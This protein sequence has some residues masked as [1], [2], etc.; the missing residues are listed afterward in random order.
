MNT[1]ATLTAKRQQAKRIYGLIARQLE[2][3]DKHIK[4][5]Q[6]LDGSVDP[7]HATRYSTIQSILEIVIDEIMEIESEIEGIE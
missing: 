4:A 6:G 1:L 3:T 2:E 7:S 5:T